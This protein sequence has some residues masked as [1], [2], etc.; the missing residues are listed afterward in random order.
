MTAPE[1][2]QK[3]RAN[4]VDLHVF[5]WGRARRGQGPT[6]LLAHATGFHARCWDPVVR[7]LAGF[8]V[9][10]VDQRGHGR[11]SKPPIEHWDV[12]GR[13]L[14]EAV[15]ALDLRE[16]VGVGH[17]MGGHAM[18]DAAAA[19]PGRFERLVLIDPVIAARDEYG[20]GGWTIRMPEGEPH[21][22][23]KRKRHFASPQEMIDRF[24]D[25]I[26]YAVFTPE[27]LEAYCVHGLLPVENGAGFELACPPE[28]EA[29]IYMTSRTNVGV[30]DSARALEIPVR[31]LRA[32]RPPP[33]R[34]SMDFSSS[35]T[36]V[37]L[38]GEFQ[39]GSE[40]HYPDRTHFLP[41][42]IPEE[43]A[44]EIRG[45]GAASD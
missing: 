10:A 21:P 18:V 28:L 20:G 25:R 24:R 12:F 14:S 33:D 7:H 30:H 34:D 16:V 39:K 29:S 13:D 41:M 35:P 15:Q 4:G 19:V 3:V 31:V 26:P 9:V 44:A 36:W 32:R 45:E 6:L 17:S 38:V 23:S 2:E 5:E 43:M 27:A 8:H 37:G 22:T 40:R 1:S 42:E 11:S